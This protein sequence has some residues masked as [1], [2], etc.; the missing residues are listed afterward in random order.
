[1]RDPKP[2]QFL[3]NSLDDLRSFPLSAKREAGY[4]LDQVQRGQEPDDWKPMNTVGPGVKEI[5]IRDVSGAFRVIYAAKFANAVYVIHCFQKKSE[6]TSRSDL[7]LS[8]KRY[9]ELVKEL[10]NE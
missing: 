2:I 9:R 5:R 4:Q 10:D 7:E 1:M 8:V 3:G 6:K